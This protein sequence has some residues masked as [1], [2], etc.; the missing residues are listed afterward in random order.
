MVD[1]Y[2]SYK[3]FFAA[4]DK[5][6]FRNSRRGHR[7]EN[8]NNMRNTMTQTR[9]ATVQFCF[10]GPPEHLV[11][12]YRNA[13]S[14]SISDL[15]S[16]ELTR[17]CNST[18]HRNGSL[19]SNGRS[20]KFSRRCLPHCLHGRMLGIESKNWVRAPAFSS[21]TSL[22]ALRHAMWITDQKYGPNVV[23]QMFM[24]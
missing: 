16:C 13:W 23:G 10:D 3:Q 17:L 9:N 5:K 1:K 22:P 2:S 18:D 4:R 15:L 8:V 6:I 21:D 20:A 12:Q 11:D 19:Q 24:F 7:F 14:Y